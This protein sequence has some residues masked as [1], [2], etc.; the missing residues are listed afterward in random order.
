MSLILLNTNSCRLFSLSLIITTLFAASISTVLANDNP[1]LQ[2]SETNTVYYPSSFSLGTTA[3]LS[4]SHAP[5]LGEE[6]QLTFIVSVMPQLNRTFKD[7][8]A[9][10]VLPEGFTLV[11]GDLS[12]Q[13]DLEPGQAVQITST[14]KATKTG[15]WSI[16]GSIKGAFDYLYVYVSETDATVSRTPFKVSESTSTTQTGSVTLPA[17]DSNLP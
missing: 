1:D 6:A 8:S 17:G 2:N 16:G 10:V 14:I 9:Q 7:L 11:S 13:G 15:N 12:W 3:E 5:K 4:L